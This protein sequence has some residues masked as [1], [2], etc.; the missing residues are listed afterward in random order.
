MKFGMTWRFAKKTYR[1][2]KC[3]DCISSICMYCCSQSKLKWCLMFAT[4]IQKRRVGTYF[5]PRAMLW[6]ANHQPI[7]D[8]ICTWNATHMIVIVALFQTYDNEGTSEVFAVHP[9]TVKDKECWDSCKPP[10]PWVIILAFWKRYVHRYHVYTCYIANR[11]QRI[12]PVITQ[13][14]L[15]FQVQ[16]GSK[17]EKDRDLDPHHSGFL[18]PKIPLVTDQSSFCQHCAPHMCKTGSSRFDI[19]VDFTN[20][21]KLSIQE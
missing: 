9:S 11:P 8:W 7:I 17:G 15:R 6:G 10:T 18:C 4:P 3:K 2:C 5:L 14:I 1:R 20:F 19:H 16:P 13:G 21:V 12:I